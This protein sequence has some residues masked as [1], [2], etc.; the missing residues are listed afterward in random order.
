[1][2]QDF[3]GVGRRHLQNDSYGIA[4]FCFYRAIQEN[5]ANAGAWNGLSL[6]LSLMRRE[7]D[8]Q[9][10]LARYAL[11]PQLPY[12]K[13]M[14]PIA[15]MMFRNSPPAM[16]GWAR[17]TTGRSGVNPQERQSFLKMA[18]DIEASYRNLVEERGEETLKRQ[19]MLTL[20][21]FAA[22]TIELD[23]ILKGGADSLFAQAEAWVK[24][25]NMVLTAVRML[26]LLPDP[27]SER[28]LRRVCRDEEVPGKIRT[29][30][31]LALRWLGVRGNV[32]LQKMGESFVINLDDPKPELTISVPA[33]YKP[34][35][36]RM[37]L[38]M[39][40]ETGTVTAEEYEQFAS[41]EDKELPEPLA[42]K[43]KEAD[44]PGLLQEVVHTVIRNA[45]DH[46]YPLVPGIRGYRSWGNAFLIIMKEYVEA[47]GETWKYGELEQDDTAVLH[48]NWLL[49]ATPDFHEQIAAA[50]KNG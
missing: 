18:D 50:R 28:L 33:A 7:H 20:E 24:D 43:I 10:M 19:G 42:E 47:S 36:D 11:Q 49:S 16:A 44:L 9:T 6:A 31:L 17:A 32:R 1:M 4:A 46:Y 26:C 25:E 38:W 13:Q 41:T 37:L 29:H 35:L 39:A 48:R 22:R 23:L 8:T 15:F 40:K 3:G 5:P 2:S 21:E 14:I 34:A 12:D 27:R 45:Y 30:A